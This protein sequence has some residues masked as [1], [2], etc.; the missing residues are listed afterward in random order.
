[1]VN[2]NKT[3]TILHLVDKEKIQVFNYRN[4]IHRKMWNGYKVPA[5]IIIEKSAVS[6]F[7]AR[8]KAKED[9]EHYAEEIIKRTG[10]AIKSFNAQS[11]D[12]GLFWEEESNKKTFPI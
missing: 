1:V 2:E 7:D 11:F 8:E 5:Y 3:N 4:R 6:V 12:D 9:K 10:D